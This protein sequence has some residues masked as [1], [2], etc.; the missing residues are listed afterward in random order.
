VRRSAEATEPDALLE[1]IRLGASASGGG[2]PE[3]M[4][5]LYG[6]DG[7]QVT[8]FVLE[9]HRLLREHY[10]TRQSRPESGGRA[11]LFPLT[12]PAMAQFRT[13][14]RIVGQAVLETG[15]EAAHFTDSV[16]LAPDWRRAG[17]VWEIPYGALLPRG[18]QG[19]LVAGRCIGA[20]EDAWEV[21]RV[22]PV[23]AL[24]GQ[25]T[26]I[27][28][29]L[30]IDHGALPAQVP[31]VEVQRALASKGLPFYRRD[32]LPELPRKE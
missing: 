16:G 5:K 28:A 22:I 7:R 31:V 6:T 24:T 3:G 8:R 30:A 2:M 21:T 14:R 10:R 32:V 19:L 9:S 20:A 26:G 4:P 1:M 12:L 18:V 23:A 27:A 13:T 25:L 17:P 11:G 29:T 15:Q